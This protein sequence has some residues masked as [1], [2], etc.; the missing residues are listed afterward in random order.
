MSSEWVPLSSGA[1]YK[2]S[3]IYSLNL[4][5][6]GTF[7]GHMVNRYFD[8]AAYQERNY[9]EDFESIDKYIEDIEKDNDGLTI[10]T[11]K[12]NNIDSLHRHVEGRLE[13]QIENN[14]E[15]MGD[16]MIFTPTFYDGMFNNPL[17]L[18]TR[19]YPVEY[20]YPSNNTVTAIIKIP[21]G[22]EVESLPQGMKCKSESGACNFKYLLMA[23]NG[24][25][26]IVSNYTRSQTIFP[27]NQYA[28][29]KLFYETIAKKHN[30]KIVLKKKA[31][32][33]TTASTHE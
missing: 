13:V 14:V 3:N 1:S 28:E 23:N 9:I 18:E 21:E 4:D 33:A 5:A 22:Y 29:L 11:Y 24:N 6:D 27:Y 16:L 8:Y 12:I 26:S 19:E 15:M 25:I 2:T 30:E 20:Y 10:K 31:D 32:N 17:K 7:S